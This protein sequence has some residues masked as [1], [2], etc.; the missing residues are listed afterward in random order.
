MQYEFMSDKEQILS[1][2]FHIW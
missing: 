2:D 1:D